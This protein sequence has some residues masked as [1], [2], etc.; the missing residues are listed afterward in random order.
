MQGTVSN[1]S[2]W[3]RC[4]GSNQVLKASS[5]KERRQRIQLTAWHSN[6]LLSKDVIQA[7]S[8]RGWPPPEQNLKQ[9]R[10]KGLRGSTRRGRGSRQMSN[11]RSKPDMST[12][13][14][15]RLSNSLLSRP[16]REKRLGRGTGQSWPRMKKLRGGNTWHASRLVNMQKLTQISSS[17]A[18]PPRPGDLLHKVVHM[19]QGKA[20]ARMSPDLQP[21]TKETSM[22]AI[23][24][25]HTTLMLSFSNITSKWTQNWLDQ[26]TT[27]RLITQPTT[28]RTGCAP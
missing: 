26:L 14:G 11:C 15:C 6:S 17:Q 7:C 27:L 3:R 19:L 2:R 4:R 18:I 8:L 20:Q 9:S 16:T 24:G 12:W 21:N 13:T 28:P 5:R 23:H 10:G 25:T 1:N 22:K